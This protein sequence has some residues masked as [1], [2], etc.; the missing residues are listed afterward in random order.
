MKSRF[1]PIVLVLTL[2]S[3]VVITLHGALNT[4]AA[5]QDTAVSETE[6]LQAL[7]NGR[8]VPV[9]PGNRSD[10]LPPA[11]GN[12]DTLIN[13]PDSLDTH[14]DLTGE[15]VFASDRTGPFNLFAQNADNIGTA[16]LL[17]S[18]TG[19][20]STPV[21]SPD[22]ERLVFASDRDGDFE[23]YLRQS[24]GTEQKLTNNSVEDI[25]PSWSPDGSRILFTSNRGGGYYQAYT[26]NQ[27]GNDVQQV[28]AVANNVLYPRFSPDGSRIAFMRAS[29]AIPACDWNWDIWVMNTNG[30]N[31]VRVT[32]QLG[33]DIYPNWT[34]DGRIIY[35]SCRNLISSNLYIVDLDSSIETQVTDWSGDE[36]HAVYSPDAEHLVFNATGDGNYEVYIGTWA[37][38]TSFNLTKN[39]AANLTPSWI[40]Q[41]FAPCVGA[42]ATR[43]ILMV[44]GWSGSEGL[45]SLS[46]DGQLK[47]FINHLA[48]HGYVEGCNLFYAKDVSPYHYLYDDIFSPDG[49]SNA[50]II[51]DNLC[52]YAAI[53]EQKIPGWSGY[54]D[55]IAHS[56]GGLRARAF[57]ERKDLYERDVE[58]NALGT[59]CQDTGRVYV[60]NL[61]TMG[62]PHGGEWGLLPFDWIIGYEAVKGD[63][64][65][66]DPEIPAIWEMLPFVR[67]WQNIGHS[68]PQ[69]VNYFLMAGDARDQVE[70]SLTPLLLAYYGWP[71]DTVRENANDFAV[72]ET[73]AHALATLPGNYPNIITLNTPDLHGQVPSWL[74]PFGFLRS[75]VNPSATFEESICP[76]MNLAG[77]Q[78]FLSNNANGLAQNAEDHNSVLEMLTEQSQPQPMPPASV[79]DIKSG[80]LSNSDVVTGQFY[81]AGSGSSQIMLAWSNGGVDLT[82]IDPIGNSI[83]NETVTNDPNI[84]Y[85]YFDA[86]L[87]LTASYHITNTLSGTWTYTITADSLTEMAGYRLL[88]IPPTPIAVSSSVPAWIPNGNSVVITATVSY[89][90]TTPVIGGSVVARIR[91]PG[92]SVEEIPLLDDGN[93]QDGKAN[94]GVFGSVYDQTSDGGIYSILFTATGNYN[95]EAF[96]RTAATYFSVAP[97]NANLGGVYSDR[98]ISNNSLG[99]YEVLEVS[100]QI[101]V[102]AASIYVLSAELYADSIFISHATIEVH[103]DTGK[104]TVFLYFDG[105]DIRQAQQDG[106]YTLRNVVLLDESQVTVLVEAADN[107]YT[108]Q[109]YSYLQF[110]NLSEIYLPSIIRH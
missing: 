22:G 94:D 69:N 67:E 25:H 71:F 46:Q 8:L 17:V 50:T 47:Y 57:L 70:A 1:M 35:A 49:R 103:L 2:I 18:S 9:D 11:S 81:L 93:H 68:Q 34:P 31:Q 38:G 86:G 23:I 77:C 96:E 27:S 54:F 6:S 41:S 87:G 64:S 40:S 48:N 26:M 65:G 102:N 44:T 107:V 105:D 32:T 55:I 108:T 45:T 59:D 99:L 79:M 20:D 60:K 80:A 51:R 100:S 75:F 73:S 58:D 5:Q 90:A 109:A 37:D 98:G 4:V 36:L 52:E 91:Q 101:E 24:N 30:G 3:F 19:N 13:L 88:A 72:H 83:T 76:Y 53:A 63:D 62:T 84:D 106:P 39:S 85:I 92:N 82:L 14:L 97:A 16:D 42:T 28:G 33:G 10:N 89:S 21:W 66:F 56:Y 15:I 95:G 29:I 110:G 12:S 104:Q 78:F 43:P 7:A 61:F 74:D